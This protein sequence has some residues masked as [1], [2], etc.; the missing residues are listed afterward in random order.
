MNKIGRYRVVKELGRGAM[1]VVYLAI[2]PNIGRDVAIKTIRLREVEKPE[3]RERLR[4]RLFREARSAGILS[5]PG[6]VTIY[7]VEQQDS[8]AYIAMEYVDGPTLDQWLSEQ[9]TIPADWMFSILAQTANAL[10]YAHGKGIV[11]RDIKPANI[12]LAGDGTAKITDFGIA[13][14]TA[15]EQFTMT[16]SIVGTPHYMSPEQVQGQAVDGRSDQFSLA[17]M[18]YEMLTGEKPYTGEHL[19]TVVYK[20]VAEDPVAPHRLNPTLSGPIELV[21]RKA[22]SKKPE[23][24]YR[25][26]RE[27]TDALEKACAATKGWKTMPRGSS[28]NEPTA[29]DKPKP[30]GKLPPAR[31]P[32]REE[33]VTNER[34]PRKKGNFVVFLLAMMLL[35]G[36]IALVALEYPNW[37]GHKGL[38]QDKTESPDVAVDKGAQKTPPT[39]NP[40]DMKPSPMS[41]PSGDTAKPQETKPAPDESKKSDS[42]N[43]QPSPE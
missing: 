40:D 13:K 8:V 20:I 24:R 3:E 25:T 33:S 4:E 17:V 18:T 16:G 2:D 12:M 23:G 1:G 37:T 10:D 6:I 41:P 39:A 34:H 29:L 11:H 19:T 21:L 5:H 32:L 38:G 22:M 27:F 26:C 36:I 9:Q 14:V 30:A 28:S 7:D 31:H 35:A 15:S 42:A 43:S